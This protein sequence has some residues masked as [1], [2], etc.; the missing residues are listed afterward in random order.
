MEDLDNWYDNVPGDN[1]PEHAGGP[2]FAQ[3]AQPGQPGDGYLDFQPVE[4]HDVGDLDQTRVDPANGPDDL[5]RQVVTPV[6][7]DDDGGAPTVMS[8]TVLPGPPGQGGR[9]PRG[10]PPP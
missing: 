3:P 8:P 1:D 4:E 9:P 5:S 6:P 2:T 7:P 10:F